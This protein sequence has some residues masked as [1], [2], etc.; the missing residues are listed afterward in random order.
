MSRNTKK[1]KKPGRPARKPQGLG[2]KLDR[3]GLQL[4]KALG[5]LQQF[6]GLEGAV[7]AIQ[8]A[9]TKVE[10]VTGAVEA[11]EQEVQLH[12]RVLWLMIQEPT[13]ETHNQLVELAREL[14]PHQES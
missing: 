6:E 13:D 8:E 2:S 10:G 1:R 3:A 7:E 12:R 9:A 5:A 11:L 14:R 4:Q